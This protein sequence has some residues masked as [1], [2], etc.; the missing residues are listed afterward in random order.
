M[1]LERDGVLVLSSKGPRNGREAPVFA[2]DL[3][4]D[5]DGEVLIRIPLLPSHVRMLSGDDGS[6]RNDGSRE[7]EA[8]DS[9]PGSKVDS[10]VEDL[11]SDGVEVLGDSSDGCETCSRKVGED[12][13]LKFDGEGEEHGEEEEETS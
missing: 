5:V 7:K 11:D 6:D 2:L 3:V 1:E 4:A 13:G 9:S 12:L 10:D 8:L